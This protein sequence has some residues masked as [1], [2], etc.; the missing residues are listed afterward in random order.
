MIDVAYYNHNG[1]KQLTFNENPFYMQYGKG[2]FKNSSWGYDQQYGLYNN[3]RRDK[4]SYPFSVVINSDDPA[5]Y[6]KFCDVFD[7]DVQAEKPGYFLINGWRLDCFVIESKHHFYSP[8]DNVID[9]EAISIS[10][11][12]TREKTSSY[13]GTIGGSSSGA[14]YGRD[15]SY[16]DDL[17]GRGYDYGYSTSDNGSGVIT[18]PGEGNG[19]KLLVYGPVTNPVVY[20]NN[21]PIRV[22]ITL[23]ATQRLQIVSNG[24]EKRIEVLDTIGRP[25]NAFVYRDK[26]YSP[27][28]EIGSNTELTYG[29][30]KFDITSIERR[31][32]PTWS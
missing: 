25:T 31:S 5:D 32:E 21:Y 26:D 19:Y 16:T 11:A 24:S 8:Y 23:D 9:F 14:D 17:M 3:F 6:D 10:K 18:L 28:I 15:Y 30:I 22:N 29:E 20:F 1:I 12:W 27:F 4:V 2:E 7:A 13:D